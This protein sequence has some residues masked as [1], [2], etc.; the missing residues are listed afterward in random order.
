MSMFMKSVIEN[1]K[2]LLGWKS[3]Q[4]LNKRRTLN[5]SPKWHWTVDI[6]ITVEP[7][8]M[9]TSP[10]QPSLHNS[11]LSTVTTSPQQPP[12]HNRHLSTTDTSLQWPPLYNS[13]LFT[14]ATSLQQTPLY[15]RHLSTTATSLQQTPLYNSHLFTTDTSLQQ[16]PLYN[17]H[18]FTTD[19]SLQRPLYFVPANRPH[20]DFYLNLSTTATSLQWQ[21][22]LNSV[23]NYQNNLSTTVRFFSY[24]WK[25]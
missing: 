10:Q 18:L 19:T 15:N 7:P 12:L 22:P 24:W 8:L 21:W 4:S 13:H 5:T 17:R 11:H 16:P 23:P 14:T 20:L 2:D 6:K 9:A 25:C 1:K 3:C